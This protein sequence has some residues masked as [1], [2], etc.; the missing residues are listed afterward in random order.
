MLS[1]KNM[2]WLCRTLLWCQGVQVHTPWESSKQFSHVLRSCKVCLILPLA[3][4]GSPKRDV[5][6]TGANLSLPC[7]LHPQAPFA[8]KTSK[9]RLHSQAS[10]INP[11]LW[12]QAA[13]SVSSQL[14]YRAFT[15]FPPHL[16]A[17]EPQ[18]SLV[19]S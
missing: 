4:V 15:R 2:L 13:T 9:G 17:P 11:I 5:P 3:L 18:L 6:I 14:L 7:W 12:F 1:Y 19:S 16:K 8:L 10:N